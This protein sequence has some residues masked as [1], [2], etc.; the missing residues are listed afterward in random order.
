MK[1]GITMKKMAVL[2]FLAHIALAEPVAKIIS[3]QGDVKVRR[4]LEEQWHSASMG[5][6]LESIDTILCLEGKVVL[7]IQENQIFHLGSHSILDIGDLRT[8]TRQ[9]L[10]LYLMA[11]KLKHLEPQNEKRPLRVGSVSVVHGEAKGIADRENA[12]AQEQ[13]WDMEFNGAQALFQHKLY[14]NTIIKLFKMIDKYPDAP[15]CGEIH[16]YIGGAFAGLQE[17]GQAL[18]HYQV[19]LNRA[20][21]CDARARPWVADAADAIQRLRSERTE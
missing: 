6:V 1:K 9:E 19:C 5:M 11:E 13:T 2:L 18:D 16:Y 8:V 21:S 7:R 10:F 3:M 20:Q 4:G 14:S 15:D 17:N 12:P